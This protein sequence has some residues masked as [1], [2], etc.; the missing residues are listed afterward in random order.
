MGLGPDLVGL[1]FM[2]LFRNYSHLSG[3]FFLESLKCRERLL[4]LI[5]GVC[6]FLKTFC[7]FHCH[8]CIVMWKWGLFVGCLV[9]WSTV[10]FVLPFVFNCFSLGIFLTIKKPHTITLSVGSRP[11]YR[12]SFP[13]AILFYRMAHNAAAAWDIVGRNWQ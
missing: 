6:I 7:S 4:W 2:Y 3:T 8:F 5:I 1:L 12:Y 10:L 13:G 9:R 11:V